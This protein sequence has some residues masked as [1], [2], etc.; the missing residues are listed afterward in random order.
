MYKNTL[1]KQYVNLVNITI[2]QHNFVYPCMDN[3]IV[4]WIGIMYNMYNNV[5]IDIH[6]CVGY[7][8][9]YR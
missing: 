2:N 5:N 6:I 4:I 9:C 7:K 1:L 8:I 3:Y